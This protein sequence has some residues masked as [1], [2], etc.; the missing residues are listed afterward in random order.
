MLPLIALFPAL[1][2]IPAASD[3]KSMK[4]EYDRTTESDRV[5]FTNRFPLNTTED[6]AGSV[7]PDDP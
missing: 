6:R 5:F 4:A 7:K 3:T 2:L 1:T